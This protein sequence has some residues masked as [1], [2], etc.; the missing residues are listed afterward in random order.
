M[1]RV[2]N[3]NSNPAMTISFERK[4]KKDQSKIK[5]IKQLNKR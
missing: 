2:K 4:L 3:E 5:S 1:E